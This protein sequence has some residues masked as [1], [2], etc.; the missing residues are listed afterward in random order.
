MAI[1]KELGQEDVKTS[2]SFLNQLIDIVNTDISSST[3][4]KKYQ[5]FV[6]GGLGPGVTSSLFQTVF[7]QDFTLQTANPMFDVTFGFTSGS[8]AVALAS[9]SV[10]S[11]GKYIFPSWTVQMREKMDIYKLFA[12]QLLGD[13]ETKFVTK[14]SAGSTDIDDALFICFKRLFARDQIKR[15]TFAIRM[16]VSGHSNTSLG[17]VSDDTPKIFTDV[18]SATNKEFDFGGQI[19][20]MVDSS[21]TNTSVGQL[22]ID[23]GVLVL[24]MN[25][26]LDMNQVLTGVLDSISATGTSQFYATLQQYSVSA[27]IDDFLDHVCMTRFVGTDETCMT[28]QNITNIN[29]TLYFCRLASDE[30]NY[31]SNPSY[32][33][34]DNRIVVIDE[35]QEETQKS[36]TFVSSIGLYDALDNL[37][38]VAKVSR[39][40]LKDQ[41]RDLTLKIRLDW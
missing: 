19:S 13:S 14:T 33:D 11:N 16:A 1:F 23:R 17:S 39:P 25:K 21:N 3:S 6:T 15:E 35:G 29:S 12:Q 27:S 20:N 31:S 18:G 8:S 22:F 7:D 38:A 37:L 30:F 36:F 24:D 5:V 4:R 32:L 40:V 26:V 28:F 10:D 34:E 2:K 9:G 41:D